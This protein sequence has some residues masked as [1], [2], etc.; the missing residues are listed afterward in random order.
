MKCGVCGS[1]LRPT[2]TDLPFKVRKT[3]ILI[4]KG[5]P[6][7]ECGTCSEYLLENSVLARVEKILA[8]VNSETELEIVRY[9]A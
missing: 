2:I 5:L 9:A 6:A 3:A 7:V 8:R 4:V 1:E